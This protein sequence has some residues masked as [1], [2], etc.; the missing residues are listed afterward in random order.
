MIEYQPRTRNEESMDRLRAIANSPQSKA[1]VITKRIY[2][3]ARSIADAM[4]EVHGG[5]WSIEIDYEDCFVLI[6]RD[7][8][9]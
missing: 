4:T 1:A 8:P 6:S 3:D 5:R 7:I 2:R 9:T